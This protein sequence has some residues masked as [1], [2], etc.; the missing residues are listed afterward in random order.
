MSPGSTAPPGTA[1]RQRALTVLRGVR[2]GSP[3]DLALAE[4]VDALT[5][6]DRRF[7]HEVTAGVLRHQ[8]A[9]DRLL[10]PLIRGGG[11][12]RVQPALR[13]ILRIGAYQLT[14]LDRVPPHA[15]VDTSVALARDEGGKK[16]A[17]FVNAVLRRLAAEPPPAEEPATLAQAYSHPEWIVRRWSAR[18]GDD[19]TR[20]LLEWNNTP[21]PLVLQPARWT[22]E[23]LGEALDR[24]GFEWRSA[25]FG[26]GI[27]L[28]EGRP[29]DLPGYAAGAFVVQDAA[30]AMVAK[31][32]APP[33][34]GLVLDA[35]AAP[36]GKT[37]ALGRA[38]RLVVAADRRR[39]RIG[40]LAEN[41]RRAGSGREAV[42]VA[43]AGAPCLVDADLVLVDAP[44]TATGTMARHPDA[45]LRLTRARLEA[46][47]TEQAAL[48]EGAARA[49]CPGGLLVYATCSLEPEENDMQV[50]RFLEGHPDFGRDPSVAVP[51]EA[52]TEAGDLTLHPHIH[53]VDGAYAARLRRAGR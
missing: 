50:E 31:Y 15:A 35:C 1:S 5:P 53:G 17:G 46:M 33:A 27:Q 4:A 6:P 21:P 37:I 19:E 43:D 47:V 8:D 23:A 12:R 25:P 20:R 39:D 45:R 11:W 30:Q 29:Q 18:F 22:A 41:L 13:D 14:R 34:G 28:D 7:V 49:V 51:S 2:S 36:G 10:T 16:A 40:R 3:F 44:C 48:L 52:R 38:A 42:V 26:D 32:A 24:G 9:L